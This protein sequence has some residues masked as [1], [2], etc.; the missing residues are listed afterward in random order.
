VITA[1]Q[2]WFGDMPIPGQVLLGWF[3]LFV[4]VY[5]WSAVRQAVRKIGRLDVHARPRQVS[6]AHRGPDRPSLRCPTGP[7]ER[8]GDEVIQEAVR[9]WNGRKGALR[10]WLAQEHPESYEGVVRALVRLVLTEPLQPDQYGSTLQES[11]VHRIDDGDYQGTEIY[12]IAGDSYQPGAESYVWFDNHYGS[13]SGCDTLEGIRGYQGG[14]PSEEQV[15]G[16]MDL[17]LHM[18]QRMKWLESPEPTP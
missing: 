1:W 6:L 7:R 10:E 17:A 15:G 14:P 9:Q 4:I 2:G 8:G 12:L 18:I 13:C 5:A 3:I 11:R 16:Y